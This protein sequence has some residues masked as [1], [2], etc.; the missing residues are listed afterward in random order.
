MKIYDISQE[1]FT[2]KIYQGDSSPKKTTVSSIS[3]GD[4]YNLTDF[5][6]CA[7]NGTH[8]D[9]PFHFI[10][11][12]KTVE[13]LDLGKMIGYCYVVCFKGKMSYSNA[14]DIINQAI[15]VGN[16]CEKRILIK[17][18]PIITTDAARCFCDAGTD[19]I[20]V[21]SRTVGGEDEIIYV[22]KLLLEKEIVIL[23]G[24]RLEDI[25]EGVYFL[26]AAPIAL[27][28]SDGAPCRAVLI[29]FD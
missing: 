9:A 26:N 4:M 14:Q 20:G 8:V 15:S 24:L 28:G 25:D 22:H 2:C 1:I 16:D 11:D 13:A 19:L 18:E 3:N 23:E 10:N 6:M 17:G 5:S 7:H 21:T 29:K 12:G 27:G